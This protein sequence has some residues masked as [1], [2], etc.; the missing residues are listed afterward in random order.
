MTPSAVVIPMV[1]GALDLTGEDRLLD[2][3]NRLR[4]LD[5]S[6]AGF[7]AVEGGAAA[8]HAFLVVQDLQAHVAGVITGS[9]DEPVGVHDR[10][11]AEV[12]AVRPEDRAGRRARGAQDALGGVVEALTVLRGLQAF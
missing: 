2:F 9:E 8:P 6:R 5:A 3:G 11:R 10:G 12:L 4:H 1:N 7:G